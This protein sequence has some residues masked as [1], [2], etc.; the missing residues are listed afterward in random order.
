MR[1]PVLPGGAGRQRTHEG[2]TGRLVGAGSPAIPPAS[3][4]V[5]SD[6]R[7]HRPLPTGGGRWMWV[8]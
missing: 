6:D 8:S 5:V 7:Y 1:A 4:D 2:D 3:G